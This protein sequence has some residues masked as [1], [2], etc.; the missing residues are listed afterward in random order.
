MLIGD[1]DTETLTTTS[2]FERRDLW[3]ESAMTASSECRKVLEFAR[4]IVT[5]S[6]WVTCSSG[7]DR[8]RFVEESHR[9]TVPFIRDDVATRR[10]CGV[11]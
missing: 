4:F 5:S 11:L 7:C 9:R 2:G 1:A 6:R 8:A 10:D 3:E